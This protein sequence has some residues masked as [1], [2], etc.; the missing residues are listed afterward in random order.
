MTHNIKRVGNF[1]VSAPLSVVSFLF[2]IG[3]SNKNA[4][5]YRR[6]E[7]QA[8]P[9]VG[10]HQ[11]SFM[12]NDLSIFFLITFCFCNNLPIIEE[13][14][15]MF[16]YIVPCT[17]YNVLH[18]EKSQGPSRRPPYRT[19]NSFPN[20]FCLKGQCHEIFCFWFF[21]C[22][23]FPP[24]PEYPIRTVLIFFEN[25]RRYSQVKACHRRQILRPVSL[26]LLIP[27]ANLVS[28]TPV[29][30]NG[31]NIRLLRH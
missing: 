20:K 29:V 5:W 9:H 18:R 13:E 24:A 17:L 30:N 15:T 23:S 21:S 4:V 28:M 25:S 11:V 3:L 31:H 10:A 2:K 6:Y 19:L 14:C 7:S 26:V 12:D 8:R 16:M 22:F 27:V 1:P